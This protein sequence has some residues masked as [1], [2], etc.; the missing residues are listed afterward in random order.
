VDALRR[1]YI[2]RAPAYIA[3]RE[4]ELT[5]KCELNARLKEAQ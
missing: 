5:G 4:A 2:R 3:S 1:L